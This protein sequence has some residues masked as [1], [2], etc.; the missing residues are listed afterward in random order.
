MRYQRCIQLCLPCAT[1]LCPDSGW[2]L[3]WHR[4]DIDLLLCKRSMSSRCL[5]EAGCC[6]GECVCRML[7]TGV[8]L[9]TCMMMIMSLL[10]KCITVFDYIMKT[11]C[12][13]EWNAWISMTC[14]NVETCCMLG[15]LRLC[16]CCLFVAAV[17][18]LVAGIP[19]DHLIDT[20]LVTHQEVF[21]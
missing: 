13:F 18:R 8:L 1:A 10:M 21:A 2:P 7:C 4:G 15:W 16:N 12:R 19:W 17:C 6:H 3:V 5:L 9:L 20:W 14:A 11:V